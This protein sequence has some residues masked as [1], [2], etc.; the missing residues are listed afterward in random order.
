MILTIFLGLVVFSKPQDR[1]LILPSHAPDR[2]LYDA[3][4]TAR[5]R[6]DHHA[7]Q[8]FAPRSFAAERNRL[9]TTTSPTSGP[10]KRPAGQH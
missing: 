10:S 6:E 4:N 3:C 8:E 9:G 7:E 1:L 2:F 5:P